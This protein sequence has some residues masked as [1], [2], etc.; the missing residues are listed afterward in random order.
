MYH[1]LKSLINEKHVIFSWQNQF[2]TLSNYTAISLVLHWNI[3]LRTQLLFLLD[4]HVLF[5]YLFILM[6]AK[7]LFALH[8]P[9]LPGI[10]SDSA[11]F[12]SSKGIVIVYCFTGP[13]TEEL[14]SKCW[15]SAAKQLLGPI[16][17]KNRHFDNY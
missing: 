16:V 12:N 4:F 15:H 14:L 3:P 7:E 2:Y 17:V 9:V 1:V 8:T 5:I 11:E 10:Y 13:W 6:S